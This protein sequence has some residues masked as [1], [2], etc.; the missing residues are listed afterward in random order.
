MKN[1]PKYIK[2]R[3]AVYR[4]AARDVTLDDLDPD[5]KKMVEHFM[6]RHQDVK[7]GTPEYTTL[8]Q[9]YIQRVLLIPNQP[10]DRVMF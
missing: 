8:L 3:G 2:V 10:A 9:K 7:P 5:E 1:L 6:R 4:L